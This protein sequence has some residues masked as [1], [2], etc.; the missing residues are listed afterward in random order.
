MSMMTRENDLRAVLIAIAALA[1]LAL[2]AF[3][4]AA[5]ETG[6]G[7]SETARRLA[8]VVGNSEY[9]NV[10]R[11]ANPSRDARA[12]GASLERV[13]FE[14]TTVMDGDQD[15][16][17]SALR[18]FVEE[19]RGSDIVL[20]YYA[21]HSVQ[22]NGENYLLPVSVEATNVDA[23]LAQSLSLGRL[24]NLLSA[25]RPG[26][27]IIILDSCRDNPFGPMATRMTGE[28]AAPLVFG[29]G[30]AQSTGAAGMLIAYATQPGEL[31]YDG[32]GTHSPFTASLLRYVENPGLEI[33]LMFGRVREDVV[34]NTE[35]AQVPWVEEAVLGEFYF[36][37]P[38][39]A[40]DAKL[41]GAS[42]DQDLVF[43]RSI[44]RSDDAQDYQAYLMAFPD[45]TYAALAANRVAA[46][47]APA[48][49]VTAAQLASDSM[50]E[51][52]WR[53]AKNSLYWLGYYNGPLTGA[54]DQSVADSVQA[55]QGALHED[56]SGLLTGAQLH[57][58]HA[59]AAD[60]LIA[61]GERLAERIVFDSARLDS[62]DRG[63]SD[64][65]M[66]AYQ[67]L[68]ARLAGDPDG[69]DILVEAKA[70]LDHM[71]QQRDTLDVSFENASQQYFTIVAAT[72]AGYSQQ[73]MAARNSTV[74][75][76]G[77]EGASRQYASSRRQVFLQHALDYARKGEINEQIWLAELH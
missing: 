11:L 29:R 19:S 44:W 53:R 60:S 55:F 69:E 65:A 18:G 13:G 75:A 5:A 73:V 33:R 71:R 57:Q 41:A 45:G 66:P 26:L 24:R 22:I 32:D 9:R 47:T 15:T 54:M 52:E 72:G 6:S 61:L 7:E 50:S 51:A 3:G 27:A 2:N 62:I 17:D 36:S 46:L 34:V 12:V 70:Q 67:Q 49:A 25:A 28:T 16:L 43:W 8:F 77:T 1:V 37:D 30:L 14:V 20:F 39:S 56:M 58:L 38:L 4:I 59:A 63:I 40:G 35:G 74:R 48:V 76:G 31:A 10:D 23:I 42:V 64:I 21:G 68:V